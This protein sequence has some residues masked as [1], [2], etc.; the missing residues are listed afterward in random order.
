LDFLLLTVLLLVCTAARCS[1]DVGFQ[2][3]SYYRPQLVNIKL[4]LYRLMIFC[5]QCQFSSKRISFIITDISSH[6]NTYRATHTNR[7]LTAV[8]YFFKHLEHLV[9]FWSRDYNRIS[10]NNFSDKHGP[11]LQDRYTAW[12]TVQAAFRRKVPCPCVT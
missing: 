6:L 5:L 10:V 12:L 8:N 2:W 9:Y 7:C 3:D 1:H 11:G 4:W